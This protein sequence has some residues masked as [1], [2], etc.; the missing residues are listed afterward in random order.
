MLVRRLQQRGKEDGNLELRPGPPRP[1]WIHISQ[2]RPS[3][4]AGI[5]RV[6]FRVF[7][8]IR[9]VIP[10]KHVQCGLQR[11][12]SSEMG[13]QADQLRQVLFAWLVIRITHRRG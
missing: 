9:I 11:E 7:E 2:L 4:P 8:V 5:S 12:R 13:N 3:V 1:S 6:L 10:I